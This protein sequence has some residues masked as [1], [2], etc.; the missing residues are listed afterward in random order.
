QS[1]LQSIA[2]AHLVDAFDPPRLRI[3][4]RAPLG[5]QDYKSADDECRRHRHRREEVSLDQ[6]AECE[7]ENGRGKK[8]D[9]DI[10]CETLGRA[11]GEQA[12]RDADELA[13]IFPADGEDRPG[14]DHDLEQLRLVA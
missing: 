1:D 9:A 6:A 11:I 14:L 12:S 2:P 13:A 5:P 10:D 8:G 3:A 4:A 7:A